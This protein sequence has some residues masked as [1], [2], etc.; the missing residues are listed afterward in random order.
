MDANSPAELGGIQAGDIIVELDG[1]IITTMT[2][3][4]TGLSGHQE[5][6]EVKIRVFRDEG[7][8]SQI[9]QDRIDLN[10]IGEGEYIDLTIVLRIVDDLSF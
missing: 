9:E 4:Q 3:L 6:D 2:Q 10:K 1:E 5:G 8:S 7:L